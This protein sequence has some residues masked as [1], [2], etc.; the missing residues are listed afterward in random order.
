MGTKGVL[1]MRQRHAAGAT[2]QPDR[3]LEPDDTVG[4]AGADDAPVSLAADRHRREVGRGGRARAGARTTGVA[5]DAVWVVGLPAATGPA[6]DRLE[7]AEVGPLGQIR[8]A[9]NDRAARAQVGRDRRVARRWLPDECER[10]RGG[11][12]LVAGVEVVLDQYRD[13]VQRAHHVALVALLVGL[14]GHRQRIRIQLDDRVHAWSSLVE[15]EDA[16]DVEVGQLDRAQLVTGHLGLQLRD[17]ELVEL[18]RGAIIRLAGWG[19]ADTR[20]QNEDRRQRRN[21]ELAH[22][23][24]SLP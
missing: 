24:F 5:I 7:R 2:G 9:Q 12:H 6:A 13:A 19:A 15:L 10:S 17:R 16:I 1:G 8:L 22:H 18:V 23:H 14:A 4:V 21:K 3:W 20:W 11:L